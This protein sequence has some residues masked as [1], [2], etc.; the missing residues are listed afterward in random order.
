MKKIFLIAFCIIIILV[1]AWTIFE[2]PT[3]K[4]EV[5]AEKKLIGMPNPASVACGK[6]GG[7]LKM[8]EAPKGTMGVCYFEDNKQCEEW[9][10]FRNECPQGGIKVTG[11]LTKAA[12]Y[13]AIIGG[14]YKIKS[15]WIAKTKSDVANEPGTCTLPSKKICDVWKL[16]NG[17]CPKY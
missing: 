6:K 11:Y 4:Q 10:L 7:V 9:A 15:G 13:C 16:W 14:K 17:S 5:A 12:R 2:G 1:A 3:K 8:E